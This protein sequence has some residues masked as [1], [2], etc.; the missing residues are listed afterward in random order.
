[1][2]NILRKAYK[3][4]EIFRTSNFEPMRK[5]LYPTFLEA[6]LEIDLEMPLRAKIILSLSTNED[7]INLFFGHR[8]QFE[9]IKKLYLTNFRTILVNFAFSKR[10]LGNGE[11]FRPRDSMIFDISELPESKYAFSRKFLCVCMYVCV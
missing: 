5:V 3:Y 7:V 10:K 8:T 9:D 2:S 11:I 1:M 4:S 6:F